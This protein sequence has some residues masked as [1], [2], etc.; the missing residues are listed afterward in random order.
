MIALL[1]KDNYKSIMLLISQIFNNSKN[2]IN[3][4]D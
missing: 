2:L 3:M 1:F 4:K